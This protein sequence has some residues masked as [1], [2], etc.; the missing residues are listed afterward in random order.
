[1]SKTTNYPLYDGYPAVVSDF[2]ELAIDKEKEEEVL[3]FLKKLS[4][5]EKEQIAEAILTFE[6]ADRIVHNYPFSW[7]ED[8]LVRAEAI[9]KKVE[10]ECGYIPHHLFD[11]REMYNAFGLARYVC[12]TREQMKG[13]EWYWYYFPSLAEVD[14]LIDWY[15]PEWLPDYIREQRKNDNIRLNYRLA[16]KWRRLGLVDEMTAEEIA[17]IIPNFFRFTKNANN[18]PDDPIEYIEKWIGEYPEILEEIKYLFQYESTSAIYMDNESN[19]WRPGGMGPLCYVLKRY[20]D[21]KR[22]D[23]AWI[24]R[25]ALHGCSSQ[26]FHKDMIYWYLL[27]LTAMEPTREEWMDMQDDLLLALTSPHAKVVVPLL[28]EI[29]ELYTDS[30]FRLDD[31]IAQLPALLATETKTTVK[32]ALSLVQDMLKR[33]PAKRPVLCEHLAICF[34][35]KTE[36]IQMRVAKMIVANAEKESMRPVLAS[37]SEMLLMSARD[38]LKDFLVT[39]TPVAEES[40][41]GEHRPII[42]EDNRVAEIDSIEELVFR[43]G[44]AFEDFRPDSIE[45]IPPALIRFN[46]VIDADILQQ[47]SPAIKAAEKALTKWVRGKHFT[48]EILAF[49]FITYCGLRLKKLPAED[50][51]VKK[52]NKKLEKLNPVLEKWAKGMAG[53]EESIPF[54]PYIDT[55]NMFLLIVQ[56]EKDLPLLSTPTHQPCWI[57][58]A[59]FFERFERYREMQ[60]HPASFD[61]QVAIQRL[62]LDQPEEALKQVDAHTSEFYHDLFTYLFDRN[63][64]LPET[65]EYPDLWL[66]CTIPWPGRE[67]PERLIAEYVNKPTP[68]LTG[69]FKWEAYRQ[70][71]KREHYNYKE[72]VL[73]DEVYTIPRLRFFYSHFPMNRLENKSFIGAFMWTN[74][75]YSYHFSWDIS[76]LLRMFPSNPETLLARFICEYAQ[77][78]DNDYDH[79]LIPIL[80]LFQQLN[81]P[82][83]PMGCLYMAYCLLYQGKTTRLYA[84]ETWADLTAADLADQQLIGEAL[85]KLINSGYPLKRLTDNLYET[86]LNRSAVHNRGLEKLVAACLGQL[87]ATPRPQLKKL[88]EIY[89]EMLAQNQSSSAGVEIP[90]MEVWDQQNSLQKVI[91]EIRGFGK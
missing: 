12:F 6:R 5:K 82:L 84:A 3:P 31:L 29:R 47:F 40:A 61:L 65:I 75:Y 50:A 35:H 68:L 2:F 26:V 33:F 14:E 38:L 90:C 86:F 81:R 23:R 4:A 41:A 80:E 77:G 39:D 54:S 30:R 27:V 19:Q 85:G 71:Q 25:E 48:D 15:T 1:M 43:L 36:E 52:L 45:L 42:R 55:L 88:L 87:D 79:V 18:I 44:Q 67:M 64:P 66:A 11:K 51:G 74:K 72:D 57:D 20:S 49:Y 53:K 8:P 7:G 70:E 60:A 34:I 69:T 83:L 10:E 63:K 59:V 21:E 73:E 13:V 28:K 62:A 32:A 76:H 24:L 16:L 17:G 46:T 9:L 22:L 91:K 37:Y 89:K 78:F 58:P 56:D